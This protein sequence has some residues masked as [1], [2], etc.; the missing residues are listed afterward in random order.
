[1]TPMI[2]IVFQL[3]VFFVFTFKIVLP[4]GDFSI[5]MPSASAS[6]TSQPSE[7]PLLKVRLIA[8]DEGE[9]V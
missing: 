8:N 3:L 7:T 1:M 2:D 4:E 6:T 9:L 5:R